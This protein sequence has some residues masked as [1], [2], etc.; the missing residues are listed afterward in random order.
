MKHHMPTLRRNRSTPRPLALRCPESARDRNCASGV[1]DP[2]SLQCVP[3]TRLMLTTSNLCYDVEQ[4]RSYVV[5]Q[6]E[7]GKLP[8]DTAR[9]L[10][11]VPDF[12]KLSVSY[13]HRRKQKR[14]VP[15][16]RCLI[17]TNPQ[18]SSSIVVMRK[19]TVQ[20]DIRA[21]QLIAEMDGAVAGAMVVLLLD[22]EN[23]GRFR[24]LFSDFEDFK[25][26]SPHEIRL[27]F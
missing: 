10:L 14:T 2:I 7:E 4:L 20:S 5:A 25:H 12:E 19:P 23:M 8:R 26:L 16:M 18:R 6:L 13:E 27:F 24:Q 17:S 15:L 21:L 3:K 1:R 11:R 22:P 9:N